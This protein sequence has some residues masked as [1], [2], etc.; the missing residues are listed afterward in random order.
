MTAP[1]MAP[2]EIEFIS[3]YEK[4]YPEMTTEFKRISM[5][6]YLTFCKKNHSYGTSNISLGTTLEEEGDIKMSVSGL[7]FR[8]L[9]KIQRL[10]QLVILNKSDMVGESISDALSDMSVY[11]IIGQI[12]INRKWGK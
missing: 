7:F 8:C 3:G 4:L 1:L 12:V 10:K 5:Q 2:E 11:G 9:D 6:Q